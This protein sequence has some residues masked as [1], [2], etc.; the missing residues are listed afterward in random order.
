MTQEQKNRKA[1]KAALKRFE[2]YQEGAGFSDIAKVYIT[3][4]DMNRLVKT[5]RKEGQKR[6]NWTKLLEDKIRIEGT[7]DYFVDVQNGKKKRKNRKEKWA[8]QEYKDFIK[9][10]KETMEKIE[11]LAPKKKAYL[12]KHGYS[13]T[14][15]NLGAMS[16]KQYNRLKKLH[17]LSGE[18]IYQYYAKITI[19]SLGKS[20]RSAGLRDISIQFYNW[21]MKG[22]KSIGGGAAL[23]DF[24]RKHPEIDSST[25]R[26]LFSSDGNEETAS[27]LRALVH[28][29]VD[30]GALV[31]DKN[32]TWNGM[33]FEEILDRFED[34]NPVYLD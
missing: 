28:A 21:I 19:N 20:L 15:L 29:L 33:D 2:S 32:Q 17:M 23:A 22:L 3:E 16:K 25:L 1:I 30:E 10:Q 5:K 27:A 7:Q 6:I 18:D 8:L 31:W 13:G 4:A 11:K 34:G 9:G 14:R 26:V 24:F 12:E